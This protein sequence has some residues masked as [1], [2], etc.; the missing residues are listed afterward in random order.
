M[1]TL[2]LLLIASYAQAHC[3][4]ERWAVKTLTDKNSIDFANIIHSTI[5]E[6]THL[7][8][9]SP[10][11]SDARFISEDTIY[12]VPVLVIGYK[13]ESDGDIHFVCQDTETMDHLIAEIPNP[14]CDE[15]QGSLH[16]QEFAQARL[17]FETYIGHPTNKYKAIKPFL[18][19]VIANG[20]YDH[21]HK[22]TGSSPNCRELHP[23]I[24][25]K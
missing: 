8:K 12:E 13:L 7:P 15:I 5:A 20:T 18:V 14:L 10:K 22:Q 16:A 25:L 2:L 3:G 19:T 1:K 17:F 9:V 4:V 24:G 6:Q 11:L 23:V 21:E